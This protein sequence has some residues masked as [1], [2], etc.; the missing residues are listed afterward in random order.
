ML[1]DMDSLHNTAR[2]S[3]ITE[4]NKNDEQMFHYIESL[5]DEN[6]DDDEVAFYIIHSVTVHIV[7][8]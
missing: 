2:C 4:E 5:L 6:S 8:I 7:S 1:G 3:E